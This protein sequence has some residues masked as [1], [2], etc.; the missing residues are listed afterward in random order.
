M[1]FAGTLVK[2]GLF[3][4][5]MNLRKGDVLPGN[6]LALTVLRPPSRSSSATEDGVGRTLLL[7]PARCRQ[8]AEVHECIDLP[9]LHALMQIRKEGVETK[10]RWPKLR[11]R[12]EVRTRPRR[13]GPA[14]NSQQAA[15]ESSPSAR[16]CFMGLI[17]EQLPKPWHR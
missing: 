13:P 10:A 6:V 11:R 5:A 12:D 4:G 1:N 9:Q 7:L 3:I 16:S 15:P 8:H 17:E 2:H 14:A